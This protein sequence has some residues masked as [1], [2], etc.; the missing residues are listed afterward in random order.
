MNGDTVSTE[1]LFQTA[2]LLGQYSERS[3]RI[4]PPPQ[5]AKERR[6]EINASQIEKCIMSSEDLKP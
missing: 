3:H 6:Q 5:Q 2:T 4:E 1:L